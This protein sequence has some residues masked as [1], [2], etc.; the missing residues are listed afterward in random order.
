MHRLIV[1]G[2][3]CCLVPIE[4]QDGRLFDGVLPEVPV[5]NGS[6]KHF[7]SRLRNVDRMTDRF[8]SVL[9]L[10]LPADALK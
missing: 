5:K 9:G 1:D 6:A 4:E 10:D 7:A 8:T 3:R 2:R